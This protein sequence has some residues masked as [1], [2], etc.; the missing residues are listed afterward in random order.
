[1]KKYLFVLPVLAAFAYLA[2]CNSSADNTVALKFKLPKGTR[3]EYAMNMEMKM[4]RQMMGKD[5]EVKNTM[6]FTYLFE[7]TN[8]SANWKTLSSTITKVS[9]DMDVMGSII[10]FDTDM[11]ND[12]GRGPLARMGK[13]FGAMK[14]SQ[15][16][17]T[18]NDKGDISEIRGLQEMRE[19]ILSGLPDG[20]GWAAAGMKN[21]FDEE[22]MKQN[23]HQAFQAYPGKPVKP[24]DSWTKTTTQKMQGMSVKS[25]N[26]YTLESVNGDDAVVKVVAKM[27]SAGSNDVNADARSMTGNGQGKIHYDLKTGMTSDGDMDLKMDM[28]VKADTTEMPMTMN[29]KMKM[30]GKKL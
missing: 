27:S 9:M 30:R 1:M 11:P 13:V 7:V 20:A 17:F 26:T 29:M 10:H 12:T 6:G 3:Y 5:I 15:F 14:G 25:D 16:S 28:K 24:G 2:G 23:V 18:V 8:D 19:K 22:S 4:N 21:V